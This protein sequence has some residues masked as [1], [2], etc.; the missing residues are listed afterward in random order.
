M[1]MVT[2]TL[3]LVLVSIVKVIWLTRKLI[4]PATVSMNGHFQFK[5]GLATRRNLPNRVMTA[6]C[7]VLTV[8]KLPRIVESTM[9]AR[10]ANTNQPKNAAELSIY[11]F[12]I[13]PLCAPQLEPERRHDIR[14]RRRPA[15]RRPA[16]GDG[17]EFAR[18]NS[19]P[20]DD[21]GVGTA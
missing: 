10:M 12:S 6:T 15:F 11:E 19:A 14:R 16:L 9:K 5:P 21:T 2:K 4:L 3:S 7:A 1:G 18:Q 8:K 17:A 20:Q 13:L